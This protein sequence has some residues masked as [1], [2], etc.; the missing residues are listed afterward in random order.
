MW[1]PTGCPKKNLY[2]WRSFQ[3][4]GQKIKQMKIYIINVLNSSIKFDNQ[5]TIILNISENFE[6]LV[7]KNQVNLSLIQ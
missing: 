1:G 4:F 7:I 5:I 2:N 3:I 6:L